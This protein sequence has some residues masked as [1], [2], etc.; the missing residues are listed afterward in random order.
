MV[1]ADVFHVA[2]PKKLG[3]SSGR[4]LLAIAED[5]DSRSSQFDAETGSIPSSL[6]SG[7]SPQTGGARSVT[8]V[9]SGMSESIQMF[10]ELSQVTLTVNASTELIDV[11]E[12]IMRFSRH[13]DEDKLEFGM[14]TLK[15][16]IRPLDWFPLEAK[17]RQYAQAARKEQPAQKKLAPLMLRVP[18]DSRGF[19]RAQSVSV[20][21]AFGGPRPGK[22]PALLH[23]TLSSFNE[24][25]RAATAEPP[26]LSRV[27]ESSHARAEAPPQ[28]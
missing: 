16:F 18:G 14:P 15:K 25:R 11:I 24:E 4:H 7:R 17:L 28:S 10:E 9:G 8:S 1:P 19:L 22:Q 13:S 12:V 5:A 27:E 23:M 20:K 6:L 26:P 2:L 3:V 21:S